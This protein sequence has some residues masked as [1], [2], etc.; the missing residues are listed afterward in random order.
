MGRAYRKKARAN[1]IEI[2]NEMSHCDDPDSCQMLRRMGEFEITMVNGGNAQK[3][4]GN[5][6]GVE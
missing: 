5:V 3:F 1:L 4:N 6:M 2:H